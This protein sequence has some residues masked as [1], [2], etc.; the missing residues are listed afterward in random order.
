MQKVVFN[1][2]AGGVSAWHHSQQSSVA[3]QTCSTRCSFLHERGEQ[4]RPK[5]STLRSKKVDKHPGLDHRSAE[6]NGRKYARPKQT[7]YR[8]PVEGRCL[9][10]RLSRCV[11]TLVAQSLGGLGLGL[12][13]P[14]AYLKLLQW[15]DRRH[16]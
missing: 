9:L 8:L 15:S 1:H 6:C 11:V 3:L 2:A 4:T 5:S 13:S 10:A 16:G 14:W 7:L 12:V